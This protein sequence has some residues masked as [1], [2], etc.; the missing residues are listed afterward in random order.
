MDDMISITIL[1]IFL[2]SIDGI[3]C[4]VIMDAY[5]ELQ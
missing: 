5:T 3:D 2:F 4:V 1:L